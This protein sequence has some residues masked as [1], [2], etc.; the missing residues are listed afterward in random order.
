MS[1]V[2]KLGDESG[3]HVISP[4]PQNIKSCPEPLSKM[5][6]AFSQ[7]KM[8]NIK[9]YTCTLVYTHIHTHMGPVDMGQ[10]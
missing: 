10:A 2:P 9:I 4:M 5:L 8:K 6:P 1:G 3:L 7:P